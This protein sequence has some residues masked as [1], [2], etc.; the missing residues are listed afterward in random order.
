MARS[1]L[2]VAI[3]LLAVTAGCAGFGGQSTTTTDAPETTA[4]PTRQTTAEPT[5]TQP[6]I[7]APGFNSG[8][9]VDPLALA[10]AHAGWLSGKSFAR[11]DNQTTRT[12]GNTSWIATTIRV[13][14][15]S[16]WETRQAFSATHSYT[17]SGG[18]IHQYAN[19]TYVYSRA[20][21]GDGNVSYNVQ[22]NGWADASSPNSH[23]LLEER[24]ARG[25][26]YDVF[27][28]AS[29][30]TIVDQTSGDGQTV[31]RVLGNAS[32]DAQFRGDTV[33]KFTVEASV[34]G[35]GFVQ[36]MDVSYEED[37]TEVTRTVAFSEVGETTVERPEWF[38]TA[39][40]RTDAD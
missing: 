4:E 14:N 11:E 31:Y 25:Y 19:A 23:E 18:E 22:P 37:G 13:E 38:D 2:V 30:T 32:G 26:V 15:A 9:L 21:S 24:H 33:S 8:T 3:A 1:S 6:V 16:R 34:T 17:D 40:N 36:R 39:V 27:T 35:D 29:W 20:E 7:A 10:D 28:T 5:Q 12:A